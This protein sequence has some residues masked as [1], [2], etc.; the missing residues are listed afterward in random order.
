MYL[1]IHMCVFKSIYFCMDTHDAE[2]LAKSGGLDR[3]AELS[4][5]VL[6]YIHVSAY[7]YVYTYTLCICK[8]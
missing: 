3:T 2:E 1:Y 4:E 5:V 7:P 8:Y 6:I